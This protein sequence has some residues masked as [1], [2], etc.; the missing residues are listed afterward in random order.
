[1]RLW[2]SSTVRATRKEK[3]RQRPTPKW[4]R[5]RLGCARCPPR[6]FLSRS[7]VRIAQTLHLHGPQTRGRCYPGESCWPDPCG[8]TGWSPV[9]TRLPAPLPRAG[10]SGPD[11]PWRTAG[12]ARGLSGADRPTLLH[13]SHLSKLPE[14]CPRFQ[15][16]ITRSTLLLLAVWPQLLQDQPGALPSWGQDGPGWLPPDTGPDPMARFSGPFT[17]LMRFPSCMSGF[18]R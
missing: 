9:L 5:G 4:P 7:H 18:K 15:E 2:A 3:T 11:P 12:V 16:Q 1:M 17:A 6:C 14:P 13:L 8:Q 10:G